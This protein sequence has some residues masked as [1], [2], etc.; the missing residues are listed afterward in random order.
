MVENV[1]VTSRSAPKIL[2][3]E[4]LALYDRVR[5]AYQGLGPI[6]CTSCGYCMPCPTGVEIPRN[7]EI[8]ND[9]KMYDDMRIGRFYYR[10][11]RLEDGQRADQCTECGECVDACPQE[12]PIPEWLK[13]V[14]EE[15]GP[16]PSQ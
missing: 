4:E 10:G 1:A 6:P 15:L 12:I 11:G 14:H 13:K 5:E 8:Y 2:A 3:D 9:A 16:R 7:F